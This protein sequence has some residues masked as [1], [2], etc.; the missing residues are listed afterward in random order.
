[1]KIKNPR[2]GYVIC[3]S[4]HSIRYKIYPLYYNFPEQMIIKLCL[5]ISTMS[6]LGPAMTIN[7]K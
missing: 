2:P 4:S 3:Q 6:C 1:M 5:I 7:P